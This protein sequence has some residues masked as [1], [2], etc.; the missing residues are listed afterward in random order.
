MIMLL[1]IFLFDHSFLRIISITFTALLLTE[2]LMVALEIHRW[3]FPMLIA[4]VPPHFSWAMFSAPSCADAKSVSQV[5]S[6]VAYAIAILLLPSY[7][8]VGFIFSGPFW[9]KVCF[10]ECSAGPGAHRAH[11]NS[12]LPYRP[13]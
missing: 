1:S 8:D 2:L 10:G 9:I 5:L 3:R 7:F 13:P 4:Q 11:V 12:P 6:L